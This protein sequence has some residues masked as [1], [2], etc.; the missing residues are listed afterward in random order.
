VVTTPAASSSLVVAID[1]LQLDAG[2]GPCLDASARGSSVYAVDLLDDERW[3][4]FGPAA[5][6]AGVRSIAA[7][8]LSATQQGALN[9]Y[10]AL[11]AAFGATDRA[12]GQLFATSPDWRSS[13]PR[14]RGGRDPV[15]NLIDA[16]RTRELIDRPRASD[17]ARPDHRR[18]GFEVLKRASQHM[19]VKLREVAETVVRT[20]EERSAAA[21]A[22]R[23]RDDGDR[24]R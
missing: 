16:L 17:G 1:Q 24:R 23:A 2:Q 12:Q 15:G 9:L 22:H 18:A 6:A 10:A 8:S 19:N 20:G 5:V 14:A 11:P 13:P 21:P 4:V 7:Y 3:P